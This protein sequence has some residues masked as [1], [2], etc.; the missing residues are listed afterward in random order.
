[1]RRVMVGLVLGTLALGAVPAAGQDAP[2]DV[3]LSMQGVP[4]DAT[5]D[6][7]AGGIRDGSI[8]VVGS[9]ATG[10]APTLPAGDAGAWMVGEIESDPITD[11]AS[12]TSI[13]RAEGSTRIA[14]VVRCQSP[15][16][17]VFIS[18]SD[19]L[20]DNDRVTLRLDDEEPVER[21]WP[22]STDSTATFYPGNGDTFA[23]TLLEH[24]VMVARVTPYNS[25]PVTATFTLAGIEAALA[26]VREAC[27][28]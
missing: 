28:W 23:K 27:G 18:W 26:P 2:Q 9:C 20:A 22:M 6:Q 3:C 16:T 25:G 15:I 14:L 17:D 19:Y 11:A 13:L 21:S 24:E 10:V 7:I 1:M 5:P 8:T 12:A 4:S